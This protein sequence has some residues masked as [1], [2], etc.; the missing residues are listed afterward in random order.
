LTNLKE[1]YL[2]GNS[3]AGSI[4]SE[5]GLMTSLAEFV[6]AHNLLS[7]SLPD[8]ISYLANLEQLSVYR[9]QGVELLTGPVPSFSGAPK[10]W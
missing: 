4:P 9:Q 1:C 2:F 10:L 8:Q 5:I 3:L 6:V 7:G